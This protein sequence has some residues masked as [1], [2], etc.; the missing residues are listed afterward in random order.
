MKPTE[1]LVQGKNEVLRQQVRVALFP[2]Q[3]LVASHQLLVRAT[4]FKAR[5]E[6]ALVGPVFGGTGRG[7]LGRRR[8][9]LIRA[10]LQFRTRGYRDTH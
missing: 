4:Y 5:K 2:H 9:S 6:L 1:T 10:N 7:T 8:N 3:Y